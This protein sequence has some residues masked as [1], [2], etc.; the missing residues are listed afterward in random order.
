[1]HIN[2]GFL[3]L[4][5]YYISDRDSRKSKYIMNNLRNDNLPLKVTTEAKKRSFANFFTTKHGHRL[6]MT[7]FP[8]GVGHSRRISEGI[9]RL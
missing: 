8:H 2:D 6:P 9:I 4:H 7:L 5:Q 1:M 3:D